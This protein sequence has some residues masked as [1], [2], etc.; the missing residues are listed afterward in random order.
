MP[1]RACRGMLYSVVAGSDVTPRSYLRTLLILSIMGL[2]EEVLG[3]PLFQ[4]QLVDAGQDL[5][6]V[7]FSTLDS[8]FVALRRGFWEHLCCR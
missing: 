6:V 1:G 4:K 5:G 2:A 7:A 3:K 8:A